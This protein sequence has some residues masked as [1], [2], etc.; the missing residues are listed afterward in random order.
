MY[1][2]FESDISGP[3]YKWLWKAKIPLKIKVFIWQILQN[4]IITRD[5]MKKRKWP[6]NPCCSFCNLKESC[7]HLY[8]LVLLL[9]RQFWVLL[10]QFLALLHVLCLY[11]NALLGSM[12]FG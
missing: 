9:L 11:G 4:A 6:G 1:K 7:N 12:L 8:S 5:N 10:V 2:F 3:N